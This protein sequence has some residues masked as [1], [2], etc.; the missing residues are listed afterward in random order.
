MHTTLHKNT[1]ACIFFLFEATIDREGRRRSFSLFVYVLRLPNLA[2]CGPLEVP[3]PKLTS[4]SFTSKAVFF[5]HLFVL[6]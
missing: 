3:T 6:I 4:S 2:G 1:H 5:W